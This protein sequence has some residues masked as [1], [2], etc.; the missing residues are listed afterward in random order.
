MSGA[1]GSRWVRWFVCSICKRQCAYFGRA[2][3]PR[4]VRHC[5]KDCGDRPSEATIPDHYAKWV[6]AATDAAKEK[7]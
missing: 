6:P 1:R 4:T 2:K 5:T 3:A 7:P